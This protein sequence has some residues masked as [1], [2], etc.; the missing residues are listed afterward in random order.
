MALGALRQSYA[1]TQE[2]MSRLATAIIG[3]LNEAP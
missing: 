1:S 3:D 2:R